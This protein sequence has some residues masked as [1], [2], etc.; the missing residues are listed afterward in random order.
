M[1]T[2]FL[3]TKVP[4]YSLRERD[5]RWELG[6]QL[7][8]K[9]QLDALIIYGDRE[10]SF[11][12]PFCADSYFTNDRPGAIVIFP[13][14]AEPISIVAFPMA[15]SDNLQE[16]LRHQEVWIEPQNIF[17]MKS[18][19]AVAE[20]LKKIGLLKSTIG[21]I[22]LEPYPPFYFDGAMPYNTYKTILDNLPDAKFKPVQK[23][24]IML[25]ASKSDEE[26]EVLKYSALVG[27]KMSEAVRDATEPGIS[28]AE[29]YSAGMAI[30]SKFGCFS[31]IML[32]TSGKEPISWSLPTWLYK[33][34]SSRIIEE[35]DVLLAEIFC[36]FGM[37]ET[38]HQ[39]AIAVGS[40]HPDFE[41]AAKVARESYEIGVQKLKPNIKFGEVVEAMHKP[42]KEIGGWNIHPWIHTM[43]PF[44]LISGFQDLSTVLPGGKEYGRMGGI[45]LVGK[46]VPLQPGMT[47]AFEPNCGIGKH[48]VN[49]GGTVIVGENGAI[50]LN[51]V[52]TNLIH[53]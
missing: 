49:I 46:D 45:P 52:T 11:P 6:R 7:M 35:G 39:P 47:F 9:E 23:Q 33:P 43:N 26:L 42:V 15:A 24:F 12:A 34:N 20:M 41:K 32:L 30:A 18:G 22:G 25:T 50:E 51:E 21:V 1:N 36:S 13:K 16:R 14:D 53:V 29:I 40:I 44:G 8:E 4:T 28:E 38:Q 3:E 37:L 19:K 17:D 27:E 31:S 2:T 10:G 5:R 48:V